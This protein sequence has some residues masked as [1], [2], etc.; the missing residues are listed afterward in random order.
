M[1]AKEL[2][3]LQLDQ[4]LAPWRELAGPPPADGW[5]HSIRMALG[6]STRQAAQR[7]GVA[8]SSWVD[9]EQREIAGTISLG[10]LR[11]L[12]AALDCRLVHALVPDL[13][14]QE[15]IEARAGKLAQQE[16]GAVAHSMALEQQR[17]D[18][19]Y[20]R[21]QIERRKQ[22]LLRGRRSKLWE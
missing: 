1:N 20:T 11:R 21:A 9:A 4:A 16:V 15:K 17:A 7:A 10:Q 13:P 3:L 18:D 19:E 6:M 2:R 22:D 12:G 14:L 8:Q 5:L